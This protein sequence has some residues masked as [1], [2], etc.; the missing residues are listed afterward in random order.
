MIQELYLAGWALLAEIA[1][2]IAGFGSSSIFLP[3]SLQFLTYKNALLLVAIYHIFGN[4]SRFSMFWKH[5]DSKIFWLFGIPSVIAT[6]IWARLAGLIDPDILK[7]ILWIVLSIYAAYSLLAKPLDIH[8]SPWVWR[9]WWALSGFSAWLIGT[10]W[11]LRGAFMTLF[12]LSKESYIATIASVALLVDFTRIPL[13]F[14]Q[15][16]LDE[17]YYIYI[18]FLFVIAFIWSYI[19]KQIVKKIETWTLRKIIYAA[20]FVMSGLLVWQGV[21]AV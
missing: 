20:I 18:P 17:Q 15:W 1:W 21:W 13:Y 4:L 19:G 8:I 12:K 7:I 2:T 16:F 11:V 6:V 3:I 9:I 10:W 5:R 14:W